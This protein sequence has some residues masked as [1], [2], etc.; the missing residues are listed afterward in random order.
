MTFSL[1][2]GA[3]ASREVSASYTREG[4]KLTMTWTGAGTTIGSVE[5]NTFTMDN[6][7]MIFAYR[8]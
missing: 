1:P 4:S 8:K 7:G 3:D 2:S 6:E 5:G